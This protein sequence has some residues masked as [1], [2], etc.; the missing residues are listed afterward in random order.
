VDRTVDDVSSLT[1]S[2]APVPAI[3]MVATG[4]APAQL[5][6]PVPAELGRRIAAAGKTHEVADERMSRDHAL[7]T[8]DRTQLYRLM[9]KYG[10][11]RGDD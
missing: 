2:D 3:V 8:T 6:L 11:S 10:I 5:V 1:E 9:E 4:S 7:V